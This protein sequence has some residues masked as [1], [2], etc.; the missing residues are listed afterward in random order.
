M[1]PIIEKIVFA[2]IT[3]LVPK[4]WDSWFWSDISENLDFCWG[5]NCHS[6]VRAEDLRK[7]LEPLPADMVGDK[8]IYK[9]TATKL[10][11]TL[12]ELGEQDIMVDLES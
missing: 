6:L 8:L 2:G 9:A 3:C 11:K 7:E 12:S 10:L 1:R 4:S 5:T